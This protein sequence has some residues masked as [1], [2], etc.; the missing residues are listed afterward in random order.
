MRLIEGHRVEIAQ[1]GMEVFFEVQGFD[2]AESLLEAMASEKPDILLLENQLPGMSGMALLEKLNHEGQDMCTIMMTSDAPIERAIQTLKLGAYDFLAKPVTATRLRFHVYKAA[3]YLILTR[4]ARKLSQEKKRIRFEFIS[5]L[6]HE[7]KAP[8]NALESYTEIVAHKRMG[9][10]ISAYGPMLDRMLIRIQGMR[11][12][13]MDLLDLTSIESGERLRHFENLDLTAVARATADSLKAE[14]DAVRV[15]LVFKTEQPV[16]FEADAEDM[17]MVMRNLIS[18][19]I[20][21]NRAD[22]SVSIEITRARGNVLITVS[23]TGIGM[24]KKEQELLFREFSRIKNEKT[25]N[26]TGSG[27][28]LSIVKKIVALYNGDI[29]LESERDRGTTFRVTLK[30]K[31]SG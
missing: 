22:G 6:A 11:K 18:N 29:A 20:K 13:I 14:A 30:R 27:L 3:R 19:A 9:D 8:L 21:Y 12:L 4:Q 17:E 26:I 2:S 23:D 28:G 1:V 31:G 7:L 15:A 5:V 25:V 24:N 16:M 10:R